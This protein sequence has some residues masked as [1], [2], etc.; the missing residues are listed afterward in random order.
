MQ[1][2]SREL[3]AFRKGQ[4]VHTRRDVCP[5]GW[6]NTPISCN[7]SG[8]V[9]EDPLGDF[10]FV[11]VALENATQRPVWLPRDAIYSGPRILCPPIGWTPATHSGPG[12]PMSARDEAMDIADVLSELEASQIAERA[13]AMARAET[14]AEVVA[15]T[16]HKSGERHRDYTRRMAK[17]A[18]AWDR[19]VRSLRQYDAQARRMTRCQADDD[20][21]CDHAECPQLRDS[22][23]GRS[24]RHC[25]L[26]SDDEEGCRA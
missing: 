22:E 3:R 19:E 16:W 7:T 11:V 4:T 14:L 23:P 5:V 13:A 15:A 10:V 2:E 18:M 6:P 26:D 24:G 20:G 17:A 8:T 25:P 1:T 12:E 9:V 21:C